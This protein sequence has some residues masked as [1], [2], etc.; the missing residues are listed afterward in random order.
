MI[1][2]Y[3]AHHYEEC[4]IRK[5]Y[6]ALVPK[7]EGGK[8]T[9]TVVMDTGVV[10]GKNKPVGQNEVSQ[11]LQ[12][13]DAGEVYLYTVGRERAGYKAKSLWNSL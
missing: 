2:Y 13:Y 4:H 8:V 9:E 6:P 12:R 1:A 7:F 11:V 5:M 10:E 3:F